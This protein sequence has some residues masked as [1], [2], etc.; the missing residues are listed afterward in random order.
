MSDKAE[1]IW[2]DARAIR[3]KFVFVNGVSHNIHRKVDC[4]G[5]YCCMHKPSEHAM[6]D[7]PMLLRETGLVERLCSH[8]V[9]HPDPDSVAFLG[10]SWKLHGCDGCEVKPRGNLT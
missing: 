8:G 1:R 4:K 9:G 2:R 7:W 6:R 10:E 5:R 3:R